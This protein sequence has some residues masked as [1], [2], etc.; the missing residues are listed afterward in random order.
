MQ[1]QG[2]SAS[3]APGAFVPLI[4]TRPTTSTRINAMLATAPRNNACATRRSLY[5]LYRRNMLPTRV[6]SMVEQPCCD[7][8]SRTSNQ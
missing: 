5:P 1:I 3:R 6:R 4:I 7:H 8:E 2:Q